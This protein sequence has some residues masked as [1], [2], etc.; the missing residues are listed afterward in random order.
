MGIWKNAFKL[1]GRGVVA[2]EEKKF[3][4]DLALKVKKR[5]MGSVAALALESTRPLHGLG[6]QAL[7]F[8]TP[9]LSALFSG[10]EMERL[11]KL[12]ENPEA[13]T[14]FV[15]ELDADITKADK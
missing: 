5:S 15:E 1:P 3:L 11:V 8:L 6:S 2:E 12:L 10:A 4:R 13:V 14:F 9:M 7:V